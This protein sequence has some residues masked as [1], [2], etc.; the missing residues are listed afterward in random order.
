MIGGNLDATFQA[1]T[2]TE[3][4]RWINRWLID[5]WV[6]KSLITVGKWIVKLGMFFVK[7][8]ITTSLIFGTAKAIGFINKVRG[9]LKLF[10][11][12]MKGGVFGGLMSAMIYGATQSVV[13]GLFK[14]FTKYNDERI[15]I[16]KDEFLKQRTTAD[17]DF[18]KAKYGNLSM[19]HKSRYA[20]L[21]DQID[22]EYST[23]DR[24]NEKLDF[25]KHVLKNGYYS[26]FIDEIPTLE[27]LILNSSPFGIDIGKLN[28]Y[29]TA[30]ANYLK[31]QIPEDAD[32]LLGALKGIL[33]NRVDRITNILKRMTY[34]TVDNNMNYLNSFISFDANKGFSL[35]RDTYKE[36][37]FDKTII[38][39]YRTGQ[40]EVIYSVPQDIN[41]FDSMQSGDYSTRFNYFL[42][43]DGYSTAYEREQEINNLLSQST[44]EQR[45][46]LYTLLEQIDPEKNIEQGQMKNLKELTQ[47]IHDEHKKRQQKIIDKDI[48]FLNNQTKVIRKTAKEISHENENDL[49]LLENINAIEGY[50]MKELRDKNKIN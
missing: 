16:S 23:I 13:S 24:Y 3:I 30:K 43:N 18:V 48:Q 32:K 21:M 9:F 2:T 46:E 42:Q 25:V 11:F 1:K 17:S 26:R 28:D 35:T 34:D 41:K 44:V 33:G 6:I 49:D 38:R 19:A 31:T 40:S 4:G 39:D 27:Y 45:N 50:K 22:E 14:P 7:H 5:N 12:N 29:K 37:E 36:Y 8:P 15:E 20:F 47:R 10:G